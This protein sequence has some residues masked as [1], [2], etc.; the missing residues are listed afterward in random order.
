MRFRKRGEAETPGVY[1]TTKRSCASRFRGLSPPG[2]LEI[3]TQGWISVQKI[4]P[5]QVVGWNSVR[6]HTAFSPTVRREIFA[7]C[8]F[9]LLLSFPAG[10]DCPSRL[11]CLERLEITGSLAKQCLAFPKKF[12]S[13]VHLLGSEEIFCFF[14]SG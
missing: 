2:R 3:V 14:P 7:G 1:D 8:W 13:A 4:S 12:L 5:A 9:H 10:N 11:V 6:F